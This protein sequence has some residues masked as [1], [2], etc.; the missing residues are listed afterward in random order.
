LFWLVEKR[1]DK[2]GE[3]EGVCVKGEGGKNQQEFF[4]KDPT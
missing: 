4:H 2:D 3:K 1:G